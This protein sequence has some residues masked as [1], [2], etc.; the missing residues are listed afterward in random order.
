MK[1]A[2]KPT[3]TKHLVTFNKPTP[4]RLFLFVVLIKRTDMPLQHGSAF[5]D[6]TLHI[7][8]SL[9]CTVLY[10]ICLVDTK[11]GVTFKD[12]RIPPQFCPRQL[13]KPSRSTG[14]R[15]RTF[16]A[17]RLKRRCRESRLRIGLMIAR[18]PTTFGVDGTMLS[19]DPKRFNPNVGSK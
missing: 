1:P 18:R 15:G 7:K 13:K 10:S 11:H 3:D 16:G 19:L 4:I 17:R 2:G 9:F 14:K 5:G 8:M 6:S 12:S